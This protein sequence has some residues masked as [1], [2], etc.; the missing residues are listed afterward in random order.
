MLN[1]LRLLG[2]AFLLVAAPGLA[3]AADDAGATGASSMGVNSAG[4]TS[5]GAAANFGLNG[6]PEGG[7][8]SAGN[9]NPAINP[10]AAVAQARRD[11]MAGAAAAQAPGTGASK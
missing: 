5:T 11:A 1:A 7:P 6:G 10:P 2:L 3:S 9:A 8:R 4:T